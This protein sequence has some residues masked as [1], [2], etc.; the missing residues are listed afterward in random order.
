MAAINKIQVGE[1]TYDLG[2]LAEPIIITSNDD[3]LELNPGIYKS[4]NCQAINGNSPNAIYIVAWGRYG[5]D[6]HIIEFGASSGT[7]YYNQMYANTWRGWSLLSNGGNAITTANY[8]S[9][10]SDGASVGNTLG[11]HYSPKPIF[12]IDIANPSYFWFGIYWHNG[13]TYV[14]NPIS[15]NGLEAIAN[16]YG[17]ISLSGGSGTYSFFNLIPRNILQ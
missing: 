5:S 15:K 3:V 1:V 7:I 12:A 4:D 6:R 8:S 13:A 9:A 11:T 2:F 10:S 17:T 16:Q 14:L